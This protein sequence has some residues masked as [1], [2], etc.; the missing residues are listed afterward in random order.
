MPNELDKQ[1]QEQEALE[2]QAQA[3]REE[4]IYKTL[5]GCNMILVAVVTVIILL[6]LL[7]VN[8]FL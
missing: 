5:R 8:F 1:T 7:F 6:I 3:E 2:E 4:K